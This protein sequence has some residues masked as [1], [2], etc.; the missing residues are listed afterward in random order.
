MLN[1]L[2]K[3]V[4]WSMHKDP[5]FLFYPSDFLTGVTDLTMEERGQFITLLCLQHQK[6]SLSEKTIR[7]S[8]ANVS[9]DV[10]SKFK[11]DEEGN[12]FNERLKLEIEKR[13]AFVDSR[14]E[15]GSKGGRPRKP[16]GLANGKPNA[17]PNGKA[18]NNLSINININENITVDEVVNYF[19]E[20]GYKEESAR[21]FF[22][23]YSSAEWK[24]SNGNEVKN[25]KL[26]AKQVW[27]KPINKEVV[28]DYNN[29]KPKFVF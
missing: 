5:A 19:K 25:W 9:D 4:R 3:E 26:K 13:S 27:F 1:I 17:K 7:L 15:N 12:F 28:S 18:K 29:A 21:N 20:N 6:G 11:K 8:V 22:N 10:I 16:N 2:K 24:D 23:Y 14:R